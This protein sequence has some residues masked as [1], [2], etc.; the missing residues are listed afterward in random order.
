MIRHGKP[1]I[2]ENQRITL[3][4][5]KKWVEKYDHTGVFEESFYPAKTL[6]KIQAANIVIT[7][8]LKRSIESAK[9]LNPNLDPTMD[10]LFRETEFPAPSKPLRSI[11]LKPCIWIVLL[12]LLWISG[13]SNGCESFCDARK[14]AKKAAKLL[15]DYAEKCNSVVL[16]GHGFFNLLIARELKKM[17]W[18]GKKITSFKHW[19]C[20]TYSCPGDSSIE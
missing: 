16:V 10:P 5:F 18:K 19:I 9:L 1:Q 11:K 20:T 4:D 3:S 12:N 14:R 2:T 15:V 6:E 17:G 7:S 8:N 13:Y